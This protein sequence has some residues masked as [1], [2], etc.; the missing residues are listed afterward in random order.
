MSLP[1]VP[2]Y[3]KGQIDRAGDLLVKNEYNEDAQNVLSEWRAC[4]AYPINTFQATLRDKTATLKLANALVAQRLKRMPTIIDKLK[5][6]PSM[7]L[8]R[9]QD[10]GG[11]RVVL[12][13]FED[14]KKMRDSY[15]NRSANSRF[16]HKLV[17]E[18]DY[19]ENP[20]SEDGYRSIHLIYAYKNRVAPDYEGLRLEMQIRTKLQHNWATAVETMGIYL[21]QSLKSRLGKKEWIDFFA[22]VSSAFA[23]EEQLPLVPR[24]A[25]MTKSQTFKAVSEAERKLQVLEKLEVFAATARTIST[26]SRNNYYNLIILDTEKKEILLKSFAKENFEKAKVAY[27]E[28]EDRAIKGE[29]IEPVLVAAGSLSSLKSAYPNFFL[30]TKE[31][32]SKVKDIIRQQDV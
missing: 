8:S 24:F 32:V 13:S 12:D 21:N 6:Y 14:V 28:A 22:I 7:K 30:D 2:N 17:G 11:V 15:K 25:D 18:K 3:T 5:R 19:I 20:R 31:F 1:K 27:S 10:I 26:H 29:R 9:M 23:H 16:E 4:H